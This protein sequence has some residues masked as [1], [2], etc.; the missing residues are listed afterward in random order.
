MS[1]PLISLETVRAGVLQEVV[2][3]VSLKKNVRP[4]ELLEA[5]R[6]CKDNQKVTLVLGQEEVD[7]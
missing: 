2:F 5:I 4:G 7:I 1:P 3:S 6:A